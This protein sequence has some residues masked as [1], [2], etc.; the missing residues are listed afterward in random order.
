MPFGSDLQ[1][2]SNISWRGRLAYRWL[3][4]M[5]IG[6]R[7]RSM[8]VFRQIGSL[9]EGAQVLDAG[10]GEGAYCFYL[11]RKYPMAQVTGIDRS[12]SLIQTAQQV[13]TRVQMNNITF[14]SED[15][16]KLDEIEK[17]DLAL[18]IAV[19][20]YIPDDLSALQNLYRALKPGGHLFIE[21]PK[22]SAMARR[23]FMGL[24]LPAGYVRDGYS[25]PD[26]RAKLQNVGFWI[27]RV[28]YVFGYFGSLA[29]ELSYAFRQVPGVNWV[30]FPPLLLMAK[31]DS[32]LHNR[33]GNGMLLM[34]VRLT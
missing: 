20:Q 7:V 2:K 10:S 24:A 18:C 26:I 17:Y 30:T 16:Q 19:L 14:R 25:E 1:F 34:A 4:E 6:D 22:P 11:A 28:T 31:V 5:Y 29:G 23:H 27:E 3:G 32:M 12:A 21:V 9:P 8:H 33:D 15:A 13:R